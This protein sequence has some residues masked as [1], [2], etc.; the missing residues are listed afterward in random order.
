ML[1]R[2]ALKSYLT[3]YG[4]IELLPRDPLEKP[5]F[6]MIYGIEV[7]IPKEIDLPSMR[8]MSF[9]SNENE[10]LMAEQLD[11]VKENKQIASI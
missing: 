5:L 9:S 6:S 10:L 7:L 4:P 11:L 8:T 1:K 2:D 3:C